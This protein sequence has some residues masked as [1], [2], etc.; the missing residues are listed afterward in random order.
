MSAPRVTGAQLARDVDDGLLRIAELVDA[1]IGPDTRGEVATLAAAIA[2]HVRN[3]LSRIAD[4]IRELN[5]A[6]AGIPRI[7]DVLE[8]VDPRS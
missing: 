6:P 4:E 1:G 2:Q 8:L 7:D 3:G 5:A